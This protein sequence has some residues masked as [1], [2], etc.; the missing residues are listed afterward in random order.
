MSDVNKGNAD[1]IA[2]RLHQ[3]AELE[4]LR[5]TTHAHSVAV[6]GLDGRQGWCTIRVFKAPRTEWDRTHLEKVKTVHDRDPA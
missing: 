2:D 1:A 6:P 4:S 5:I 3:Q